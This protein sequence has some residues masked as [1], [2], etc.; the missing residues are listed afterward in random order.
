[1]VLLTISQQWP[2]GFKNSP[3]YVLYRLCC[4]ATVVQYLW[5]L[6]LRELK[7]VHLT[8]WKLSSVFVVCRFCKRKLAN[9]NSSSG[10]LV[11]HELDDGH[12]SI[13][14]EHKSCCKFAISEFTTLQ[15]SFCHL[16]GTISQQRYMS[17][18]AL[19]ITINSTVRSTFFM[20]TTN[21]APN[22]RITGSLRG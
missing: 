15:N 11:C 1:M 13:S 17:V 14:L 3:T 19:Q 21:N 12:A 10:G 5:N 7:L 9:G 8:H 4:Q 20:L 18:M 22:L 6:P 2:R 16:T